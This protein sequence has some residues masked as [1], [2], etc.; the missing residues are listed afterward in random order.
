MIVNTA[1]AFMAKAK[2]LFTHLFENGKSNYPTD[3][4][5]NV[6]LNE[7]GLTIPANGVKA[8]FLEI[9]LS[10]FKTLNVS[11]HGTQYSQAQVQVAILNPTGE[12]VTTTLTHTLKSINNGGSRFAYQIPSSARIDGYTIA[13]ISYGSTAVTITDAVFD[14]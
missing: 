11:G 4:A 12:Y 2:K 6:T 8:A 5:A 14:V 13:F 9:P 10:K 7:T 1:Y 3:F